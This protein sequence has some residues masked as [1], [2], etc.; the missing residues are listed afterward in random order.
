MR[1]LQ[2]TKFYPPFR[3]GIESAVFELTEGLVA[4]DVEVDVLCCNTQR[5]TRIDS[6]GGYTVTRAASLGKLLSTSMAPSL[7]DEMR[8]RRDA[9]DLIH[10]HMPDPMA[11]LA[12]CLAKP[13]A[14]L[15][16]HWH[17]DVIRQRLSLKLYEPLQQWL[18][19]RADA[20]VVTSSEYAL[21]SAALLNWRHKVRIM[22]I[23]IR[24]ISGTADPADVA[25]LRHAWHG[26]RVVLAVGRMAHYKGFEVLVEAAG[27]L[28]DDVLVVIAGS[29]EQLPAL[30]EKVARLGLQ[31]RVQLPGELSSRAL[32]SHMTAC[33]VYCMPSTSRAE[34]FGLAMV[35]AQ[36]FGKPVVAS[37]IPGSGVPWVNQAGQTGLNVPVGS[38]RSLATAIRQLTGDP[39]LADR[40]GR[41]A[42]QRYL[43][44]FTAHSMT[45]RTLAMYK[46]LLARGQS[47]LQGRAVST[48]QQES[49]NRT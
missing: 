33:D 31:N 46:E 25:A 27:S 35:E 4:A 45:H 40:Y 36:C 2:L 11:A 7:L 21:A 17:S 30:R 44:E 37:D 15:I 12:L 26:R 49:R 19:Q 38:A 23:G 32:A 29:G 13:T 10:V 28:P 5:A 43:Q 18:L 3:G 24:D 48:E 22:P 14:P 47:P 39:A 1:V 6:F 41:A 34:S 8:K 9:Q 16:V 42:R 20:I